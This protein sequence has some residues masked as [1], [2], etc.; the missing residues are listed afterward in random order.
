MDSYEWIVNECIVIRLGLDLSINLVLIQDH[1]ILDIRTNSILDSNRDTSI[2]GS[3]RSSGEY[4]FQRFSSHIEVLR[5]SALRELE[6]NAAV[7]LH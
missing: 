7:G 6:E 5:P 3:V 4:L 2:H 1:L